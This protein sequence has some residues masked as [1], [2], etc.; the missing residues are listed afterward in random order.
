MASAPKAE[1]T[2][3]KVAAGKEHSEPM[4]QLFSASATPS[5]RPPACR[6]P[7]QPERPSPAPQRVGGHG[8]RQDERQ[9]RIVETQRAIAFA[10]P[11]GALALGVDKQSDAA[12]VLRDAD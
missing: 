1:T 10:P 3:A 12:D 8:E 9:R 7:V 6:K 2:P 5:R 11:R 4:A